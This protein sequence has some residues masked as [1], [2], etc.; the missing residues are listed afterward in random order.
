MVLISYLLLSRGLVGND[1]VN[2]KSEE[3]K[4]FNEDEKDIETTYPKV[5]DVLE[6][7][8]PKVSTKKSSVYN[9]P[10][11]LKKKTFFTK[12]ASST[13]PRTIPQKIAL[14]ISILFA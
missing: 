3:G 12:I 4:F 7:H 5:K 8:V 11:L 1:P 10:R 14:L 9:I 13:S 6:Q 2:K